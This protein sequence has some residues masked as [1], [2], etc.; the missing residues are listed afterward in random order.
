MK[1][2]GYVWK[3]AHHEVKLQER[4]RRDVNRVKVLQEGERV[5]S[6]E[7][8]DNLS[9]GGKSAKGLEERGQELK[10]SWYGYNQE[11][12]QS[13]NPKSQGVFAKT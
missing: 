7:A 12:N 10:S 3:G 1:F 11:K 5:H 6:D 4:L 2:Q 8:C 13:S 9:H